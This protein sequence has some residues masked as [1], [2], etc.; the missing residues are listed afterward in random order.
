MSGEFNIRREVELHATPEQVWEAVASGPGISAWFVPSRVE[1]R[2]GGTIAMHF[3][4]GMDE[5]ATVTA[6]GGTASSLRSA[7]SN[8][9]RSASQRSLS[10]LG[11][12]SRLD[13]EGVIF[14]SSRNKSSPSCGVRCATT[15]V[16]CRAA[17]AS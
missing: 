13:F 15:K 6:S 2:E 9:S 11:S 14:P 16:A 4:E 1:E 8:R 3:G 5:T 10:C 7:A 17:R 12:R